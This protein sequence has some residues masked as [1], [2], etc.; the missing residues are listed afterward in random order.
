MRKTRLALISFVDLHLGLGG[1]MLHGRREGEA[2]DAHYNDHY[3]H[4]LFLFLCYS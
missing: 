3:F 1:E 4:R 2:V